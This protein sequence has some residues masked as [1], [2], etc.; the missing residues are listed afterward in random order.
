MSKDVMQRFYL[1]LSRLMPEGCATA[2]ERNLQARIRHLEAKV[3]RLKQANEDALRRLEASAD[4]A[5]RNLMMRGLL[6]AA[7]RYR[8][9]RLHDDPIKYSYAERE[10][11]AAL[12]ACEEK[13]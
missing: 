6:N 7:K 3:E 10:L 9:A 12:A 5:R 4:I 13:P 11:D 2:K 1:E 8:R